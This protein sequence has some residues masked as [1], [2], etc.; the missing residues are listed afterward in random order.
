MNVS[1]DNTMTTVLNK[2]TFSSCLAKNMFDKSQV[3]ANSFGSYD[4]PI[5]L[6]THE[7]ISKIMAVSYTH[8]TLPTI[9]LV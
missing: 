5:Q 8:L 2:L 6:L 7:F 1:Y 3:H 4:F 9:L